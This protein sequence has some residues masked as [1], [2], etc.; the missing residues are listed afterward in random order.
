MMRYQRFPVSIKKLTFN[1]DKLMS[2]TEK[3][4]CNFFHSQKVQC[5][6][7]CFATETQ[8]LP[9]TTQKLVFVNVEHQGC[10][11][12]SP[13]VVQIQLPFVWMELVYAPRVWFP[14][15]EEF[16]KR[17]ELAMEQTF[18]WMMDLVLVWTLIHLLIWLGYT[19]EIN[20]MSLNRDWMNVKR[21]KNLFFRC[22]SGCRL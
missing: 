16:L 8:R 17:K 11:I 10:W 6:I 4:L 9:I 2:Q 13:V 20:E 7:Q 18:A 12:K 5:L 1:F 14:T 21:N 3:N 19:D 22:N 15:S